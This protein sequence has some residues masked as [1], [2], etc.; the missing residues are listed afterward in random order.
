MLL[1]EIF[2]IGWNIIAV[3]DI[4]SAKHVSNGI[5]LHKLCG[6]FC[7]HDECSTEVALLPISAGDR[8]P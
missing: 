5:P 6:W 8:Y 7:S 1:S 4:R 2:C 3:D